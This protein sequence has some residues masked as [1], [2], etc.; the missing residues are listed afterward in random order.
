MQKNKPSQWFIT[1]SLSAEDGDPEW[2]IVQSPFM[3]ARARTLAFRH[4][5]IETRFTASNQGLRLE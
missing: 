2:G 3:Q 4:E 1:T 5:L